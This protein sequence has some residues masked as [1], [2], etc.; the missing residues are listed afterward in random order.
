MRSAASMEIRPDEKGPKNLAVLLL[1]SSLVVAGMGWQD[2]QLHNDGLT[3]GQIE[4]FLTT[5]NS[6]PGEPTTPEQY[7]DFETDVRENNG[8]LLRGV[9]LLIAAACLL[10]GAPMLLRLQRRGAYLCTLGAVVGLIG[11]V[12]GSVIINNAA[13]THL[14]DAMKLTYEIWVYLCGTVMGLCLAVA[15]LPLL[16]ARARLALSLI[17]D[18]SMTAFHQSLPCQMAY[19][20]RMPRKSAPLNWQSLKLERLSR[21][22]LR[23]APLKSD[24]S[25]ADFIR[26]ASTMEARRKSQ[27]VKSPSVKS[28]RSK[29]ALRKFEPACRPLRRMVS[30]WFW[31]E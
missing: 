15:A 17:R 6:Q 16:N 21:A 19:F 31:Y 9:S 25:K 2:W 22:F 1:L 29:M 3:D 8:Y 20:P 27:R 14:G 26:S 24:P 7:R 28:A 10:V 18:R 4:T 23:S 5:P 12:V 11:G 30:V 13:Q